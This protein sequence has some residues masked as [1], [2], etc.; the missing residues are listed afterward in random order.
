MREKGNKSF[1]IKAKLIVLV[2][3]LLVGSTLILGTIAYIRMNSAYN[4]AIEEIQAGFD[5]KIRTAVENIIGVL[6]VNQDRYSNG[7]ITEEEAMEAAEAIVRDARYDDGDGY[8]W[9][10]TADGTCVVHMNADN[11]GV[12][13]YDFQD[14]QGNYYIQNI[15]QAGNNADGGFT[16]FYYAKPGESADVKKRAFTMY[17]EPYGWYISTGNY[18]DDIDASIS[19]IQQK[20]MLAEASILLSCAAISVLGILLAYRFAKKMTDPIR[21][22]TRRLTLLS[23]GDIRTEPSKLSSSKDE[24]GQLT[25]AAERVI[26]QIR[27]II[28][29]LTEQLRYIS[30]GDMTSPITHEYIGD[31]VPILDSIEQIKQSLNE[32]LLT[33]E[34]STGQVSSSASEISSMSQYLASGAAEQSGS[35]DSLSQSIGEV[36][37]SS[38]ENATSALD[39]SKQVEETMSSI[40]MSEQEM[41][42]MLKSMSEI[43]E[44]TEKISHITTLI[45]NIAFQTNILALNASIEAARAGTQGKGFAVV[46]EEVRVLAEKSADAAKQ[47]E[48]LIVSTQKAVAEGSKITDKMSL[49]IQDSVSKMQQANQTIGAIG[50]KSGEQADA[51]EQIFDNINQISSIVQS[52]AATA[53]ESSAFSEELSAQTSILYKE[54]EK[55]TL[56]K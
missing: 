29:D 12:N 56:A 7:D 39:A 45:E 16:E 44:T 14:S 26:L 40:Q 34:T 31:Y 36:S 53:E 10:D 33:I 6:E 3:I 2:A 41:E 49:M 48:E 23:E 19:T 11:V 43:S 5:T 47:T 20:K 32:T 4:S 27:G 9:A 18:Y 50:V 24:T 55:F 52:N 17:F 54:L 25:K 30:Q 38:K 22:V 28:G 46:A 8:F 35:I 15:I 51:I 21:D 13:R 42:L 1:G 37:N